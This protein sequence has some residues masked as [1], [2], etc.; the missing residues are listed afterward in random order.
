M[1]AIEG[2]IVLLSQMWWWPTDAHFVNDR[3]IDR[4]QPPILRADMDT[5]TT[6][7]IVMVAV[8]ALLLVTSLVWVARSEHNRHD[9]VGPIGAD[10]DH[11]GSWQCGEGRAKKRAPATS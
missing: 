2:L 8:A 7:L 4:A 11:G 1:L 3:T 10:V 6:I 5:S 9:R